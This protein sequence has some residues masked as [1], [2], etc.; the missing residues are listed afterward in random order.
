MR[1]LTVAVLP[2]AMMLALAP[3]AEADP[4]NCNPDQGCLTHKDYYFL[5]SIADV[6]ITGKPGVLIDSARDGVCGGLSSGTDVDT[7]VLRLQSWQTPFPTKPTYFNA[8]QS[9]T[10]VRSAIEFYCPGSA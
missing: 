9:A 2:V 4:S 1:K 10:Y 6:G 3:Q 5:R 8:Q 7:L